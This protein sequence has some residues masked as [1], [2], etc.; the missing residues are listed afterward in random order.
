M[1][2]RK[3]IVDV[4]S[5]GEYSA[6]HTAGAINIPLDQINSRIE[7]IRNL[8]RPVILCSGEGN[9]SAR[10]EFALGL[11]GIDC[12]NAGSW[13]DLDLFLEARHF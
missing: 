13:A 9:R 7:E 8:R 10:A 4:R 3:S 2:A 1:K 5:P 12:I 6:G 11:K